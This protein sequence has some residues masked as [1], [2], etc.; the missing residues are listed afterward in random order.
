MR[1]PFLD[2]TSVS[3]KH[4]SKPLEL[5]SRKFCVVHAC[6]DHII[7]TLNLESKLLLGSLRI[8]LHIHVYSSRKIAGSMSRVD[9]QKSVA[10]LERPLSFNDDSP[11]EIIN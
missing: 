9:I 5:Q 8:M 10:S 3:L 7:S 2:N 4:T 6:Q 1:V 11:F